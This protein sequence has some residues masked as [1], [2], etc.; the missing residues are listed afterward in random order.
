MKKQHLKS[1][2]LNKRSISSFSIYGGEP[3]TTWRYCPLKTDLECEPT[4]PPE[5]FA[6]MCTTTVI[7]T[8][9]PSAYCY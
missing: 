8:S 6:R 5:T 2:K 3:E 9:C 1:L 4:L 7:T